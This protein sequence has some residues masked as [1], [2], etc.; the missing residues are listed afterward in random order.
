M[1]RL[2]AAI[3]GAIKADVMLAATEELMIR[4]EANAT[5]FR[6]DLESKGKPGEGTASI[7]LQEPTSVHIGPICGD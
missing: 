4:W 5:E 3:R 1:A 6:M 2:G 7:P